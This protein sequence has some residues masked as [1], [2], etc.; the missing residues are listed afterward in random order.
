MKIDRRTF[1]GG[2]GTGSVVLRTAG[3]SV[4]AATGNSPNILVLV[5]D[6]AGWKDFG[7]YGNKGIKT[8]NID[9]LAEGG[10]ICENAFLTAPQCSPSRISV[11][12][13]RYP[14]ATGAEDLHMPLPEGT[15]F[16][17]TWLKKAGYFTGHMRK[18]HYGPEG[19]KQFDWYSAEL[20]DFP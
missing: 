5:A 11:L 17:P 9:R 20:D 2:L 3:R 18:T 7:C 10:L 8:P 1:I 12:T 4:T 13:G 19:E 6:D 16:L 15:T 14:H